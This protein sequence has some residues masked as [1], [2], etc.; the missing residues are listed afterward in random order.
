MW[1]GFNPLFFCPTVALNTKLCRLLESHAHWGFE[2]LRAGP[3]LCGSGYLDEAAVH[4]V[5]RI[6]LYHESLYRYQG[7]TS[8]YI[9]PRYGL[10]ELPQVGREEGGGL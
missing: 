2:L 6:K 4:T 3:T 10:G 8:P 7:L 1:Q 5:R 9:Y